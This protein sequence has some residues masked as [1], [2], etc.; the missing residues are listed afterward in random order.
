MQ[1]SFVEPRAKNVDSNQNFLAQVRRTEDALYVWANYFMNR[2]T[3][4]DT[5]NLSLDGVGKPYS[6]DAWTGELAVAEPITLDKWNLTVEDW[7]AGEKVYV[8][9]D[10]GLGYESTEVYWTTEKT[11]IEVGETELLPWKEIEAVGEEVSGIGH[12]TTTFTLPDDWSESNGAVLSI[13]TLYGNTAAVYVNGEKAPG[14]DFVGRTLD[15]SELLTAGE[16]T[17]EIEVSTTLKNRMIA[18]GYLEMVSREQTPDNYGMAGVTIT[19]YT[20]AELE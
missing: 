16:N 5:L 6:V 20:L 11:A 14:F 12:Y 3:E 4:E 1:L 7:H 13:D 17:I 15:I 10:R 19:P 18:S 9:E 8:T 2:N